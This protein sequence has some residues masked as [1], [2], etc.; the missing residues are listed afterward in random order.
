MAARKSG[1]GKKYNGRTLMQAVERYLSSVSRISTVTTLEP[2]GELDRYGHPVMEPVQQLAANG[3][4]VRYVEYLEPPTTGDLCRV[5]EISPSTWSRYAEDEETA[6]AVERFRDARHAYLERELLTRKTVQGVVFDLENNFPDRG[7]RER[8]EIELGPGARQA[9][10]LAGM[11]LHEKAEL[12]EEL[13]REAFGEVVPG[14][15]G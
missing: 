3:E 10:T 9:V 11:S 8:T 5:L 2:T 14:A 7:Y 13:R 1:S 15:D 12:L 6:P 4:P